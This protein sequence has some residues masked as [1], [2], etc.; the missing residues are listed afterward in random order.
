MTQLLMLTDSLS[1]DELVDFLDL[2]TVWRACQYGDVDHVSFLATHGLDVN[3]QVRFTG[4]A[5]SV[6]FCST[7]I[8]A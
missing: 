6:G 2:G 3:E 1:L 4:A 8:I 5:L 7:N